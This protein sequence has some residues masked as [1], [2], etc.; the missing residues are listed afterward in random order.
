MCSNFDNVR[1]RPPQADVRTYT[2]QLLSGALGPIETLHAWPR[3]DAWVARWDPDAGDWCF[4]AWH[5][6]LVP[7]WSDT[8]HPK[9]ST[10]NARS[11]TVHRAPAFRGPW[12]EGQRCLIPLTGWYESARKLERK[13]WVRIRPSTP[14]ITFAGIWDV[15]SDKVTGEALHSFSMLTTAAAPSLARV[16]DRM[17]VIIGE[18]DRDAWLDPATT[19]DRA[20]RM[21]HPVEDEFSLHLAEAE[22]SP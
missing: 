16:H 7:F 6:S 9:M 22:A 21:L 4:A 3:R 8:R 18:H 10:F 13:G 15:W 1:P 2:T 12:R 20:H 17:P 5:W 14:A 11:E 19:P